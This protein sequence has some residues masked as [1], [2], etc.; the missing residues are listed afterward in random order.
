MSPTCK[1][2]LADTKPHAGHSVIP[3]RQSAAHVHSAIS[4]EVHGQLFA[5]AAD[6][7]LDQVFTY[8]VSPSTGKLTEVAIFQCTPGSGPRHMAIATHHS[9][10]TTHILYVINELSSIVSS[11]VITANGT[12]RQLDAASTLPSPKPAGFTKAAEILLSSDNRYVSA[13]HRGLLDG[14]TNSVAVFETDET[15]RLRLVRL[16]APG[17]SFPRGMAL[18]PLA[19]QGRDPTATFL[20][21]GQT[22][23][24]VAVFTGDSALQYTGINVTGLPNPVTI[25]V[26]ELARR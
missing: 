16:Q 9:G 12:L 19:G 8:L 24:N 15:G 1:L 20:I 2:T 3:S 17:G 13:T 6:L 18:V 26:V 25:G 23:D 7:G 5:F 14:T 22:S 21:A 10:E 4:A 11:F